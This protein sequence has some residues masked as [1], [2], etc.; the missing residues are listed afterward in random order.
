MAH[1]IPECQWCTSSG[2]RTFPKWL[3]EPLTQHNT[4]IKT[5]IVF[6]EPFVA[7]H[8]IAHA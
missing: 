2:P 3:A 5:N 4:H 6:K 1:M 7:L 8:P